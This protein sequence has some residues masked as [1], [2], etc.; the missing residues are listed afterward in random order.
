MSRDSIVVCHSLPFFWARQATRSCAPLT[1]S[2]LD[3]ALIAC[4]QALQQRVYVR[5]LPSGW[6]LAGGDGHRESHGRDGQARESGLS[7]GIETHG[8]GNHQR[9]SSSLAGTMLILWPRAT[10]WMRYG[11]PPDSLEMFSSHQVLGREGGVCRG[12]FFSPLRF[13]PLR[14]S[15]FS[16]LATKGSRLQSFI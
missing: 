8:G 15:K 9:C 16:L 4:G 2:I 3:F 6:V 11:C 5:A 13:S 14:N 1:Y 10:E 7:R 12:S